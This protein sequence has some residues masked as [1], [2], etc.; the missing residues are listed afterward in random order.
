MPK[1]STN[2]SSLSCSFCGK[3]R[4]QVRRLVAGPGVFICNEC[5]ALCNGILQTEEAAPCATPRAAVQRPGW[6]RLLDRFLSVTT[7]SELSAS[8]VSQLT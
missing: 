7:D 8:R 4:Q 5:I 1:V 2:R 3:D 6:R